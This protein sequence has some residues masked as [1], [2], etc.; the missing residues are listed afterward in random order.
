MRTPDEYEAIK[1][2]LHLE[3]TLK[4]EMEYFGDYQSEEHGYV[5]EGFEAV[6]YHLFKKFNWPLPIN[7]SMNVHDVI[8]ALGTEFPVWFDNKYLND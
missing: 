8:T 2:E 3:Y 1:R 7:R 6:V 5:Q 4:L